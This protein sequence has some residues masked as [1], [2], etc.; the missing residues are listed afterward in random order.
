MIT[1]DE[2]KKLRLLQTHAT[3]NLIFDTQIIY[4]NEIKTGFSFQNKTKKELCVCRQFKL[5]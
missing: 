4:K 3:Q 1:K 5:V 2:V